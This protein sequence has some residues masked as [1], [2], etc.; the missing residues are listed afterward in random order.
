[1]E[2][3]FKQCGKINY[4]R[5]ISELSYKKISLCI[6]PWLSTHLAVENSSSCILDCRA[7]WPIASTFH[8][9]KSH[10]INTKL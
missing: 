8:E 4:V 1:M 9:T 6:F 2:I 3:L 7:P 10:I 5:N